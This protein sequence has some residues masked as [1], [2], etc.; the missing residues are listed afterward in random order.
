MIGWWILEGSVI[1]AGVVASIRLPNPITWIAAGAAAVGLGLWLLLWLLIKRLSLEYALTT[2]QLIHKEGLLRRVTNRI[3]MI[4]IDDVTHEQ[5]LVER[6]MGV[7]SVLVISSDKSHPRLM[8]HGIDDVQRVAELIDTT[9][10][11]ERRR[12]GAFIEQ[13]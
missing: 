8:L 4:D 2:E 3:E 12:R 1:I 9:S 10:R 13:V 6:F 7:G 5:N 11:E